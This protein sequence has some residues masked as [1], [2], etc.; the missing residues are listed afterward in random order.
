LF[1]SLGV[2][3]HHGT[4]AH[5]PHDSEGLPVRG[6]ACRATAIRVDIRPGRLLRT[7]EVHG[8]AC[9]HREIRAASRD[10]QQ[11]RR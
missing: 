4:R 7:A 5:V 3:D 2:L 1:T 6:P 11:P 9:C 10:S 8:F